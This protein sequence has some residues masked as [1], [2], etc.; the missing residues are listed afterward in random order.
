LPG[1]NTFAAGW[2]VP[3]ASPE[4]QLETLA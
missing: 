2:V 3:A 1:N 4:P